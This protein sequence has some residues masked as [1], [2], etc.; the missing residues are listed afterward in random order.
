MVDRTLDARATP[1]E[2]AAHRLALLAGAMM[3]QG[4]SGVDLDLSG[5]ASE[6][7]EAAGTGYRAPQ[8]RVRLVEVER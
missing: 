5:L 7:G 2:Q 3:E 4:T 6:L 1:P 8:Q